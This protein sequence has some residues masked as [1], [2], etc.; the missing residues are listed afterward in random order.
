MTFR[1]SLFAIENWLGP[2]AGWTADQYWN[3]WAC[4]Y[5]E[6]D[7]AMQ[8]VDTWNRLTSRSETFTAWYD[9]DRDQFCFASTEAE[10]DCFASQIIDAGNRQ[11]TVY[12][13]G[14]Y[15]WV[16]QETDRPSSSPSIKP[17]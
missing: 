4:P 16:W 9:E 3:G 11:L 2:F 10:R 6:R 7:I 14:A 15:A 8:M 13:I 12:A 1:K 5:F 17:S